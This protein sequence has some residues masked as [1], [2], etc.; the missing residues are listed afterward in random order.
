MATGEE[1]HLRVQVHL[2]TTTGERS[3]RTVYVLVSDGVDEPVDCYGVFVSKK[4]AEDER[5]RLEKETG[6]GF[7]VIE[8]PLTEDEA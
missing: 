6:W 8:V 5:T 3:M 2:R 7:E 1:V 4:R